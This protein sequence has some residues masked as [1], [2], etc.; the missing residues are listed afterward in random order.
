VSSTHLQRLGGTGRLLAIMLQYGPSKEPFRYGRS[1]LSSLKSLAIIGS[2][3]PVGEGLLRLSPARWVRF[4][5]SVSLLRFSGTALVSVMLLSR[6]SIL[7]TSAWF[8][9]SSVFGVVSGRLDSLNILLNYP[10]LLITSLTP[11]HFL[12]TV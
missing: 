1:Y 5:P 9:S 6:T 8:C 12:V 4:G 10:W 11:W 7:V 2:S 3:G